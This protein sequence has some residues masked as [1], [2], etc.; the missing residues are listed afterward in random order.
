LVTFRRSHP[1]MPYTLTTVSLSAAGGAIL[2]QWFGR[3]EQSSPVVHCHCAVQDSSVA[4]AASG[5]AVWWFS[6]FFVLLVL[7]TAVVGRVWWIRACLETVR[8]V[9]VRQHVEATPAAV[10]AVALEEVLVI[11]PKRPSDRIH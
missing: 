5:S 9:G 4:V 1:F 6:L 8:P 10:A 2:G 3:G 11:R 7:S